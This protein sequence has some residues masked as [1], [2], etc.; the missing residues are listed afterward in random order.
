MRLDKFIANN[1]AYTRTDVK[2]L[3]KNK[4]ISIN[5][6]LAKTFNQK[7]DIFNDIIKVNENTIEQFSAQYYM[8]HKP[9]NVVCANIHSDYPTVL[10]LL[11]DLPPELKKKLQIAGRLD[12]DTTGLVLLTDDGQWNHRVTS[13]RSD[14][15]KM[16]QVELAQPFDEYFRQAFATGMLLEGEDKPTLPAQLTIIDERNVELGISE[17]RYHQVKRMFLYANN[18]VTK[19]HRVSIGALTLDPTLEPGA[20]RALSTDEINALAATEAYGH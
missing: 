6:N 16:Y 1:S 20:Y 4:A 7:I 18:K 13:P 10:D 11:T 14:C 19:L 8:F 2:R 5:E 17:G 15:I 12:V 9:I 3:I